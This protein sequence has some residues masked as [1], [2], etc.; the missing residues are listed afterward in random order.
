MISVGPLQP[1]FLHHSA[2]EATGSYCRVVSR[3]THNNGCEE[4]R[5]EL[6]IEPGQKC[7]LHF[8]CTLKA[9]PDLSTFADVTQLFLLNYFNVDTENLCSLNILYAKFGSLTNKRLKFY[10]FF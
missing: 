6:G 8:Q 7:V 9:C 4:M 5:L 10:Y 1:Y 2:V 3:R